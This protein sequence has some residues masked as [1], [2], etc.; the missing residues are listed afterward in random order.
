M[1]GGKQLAGNLNQP[2]KFAP[3]GDRSSASAIAGL[4]KTNF[5]NYYERKLQEEREGH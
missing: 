2:T 3:H 1:S 5:E 4:P